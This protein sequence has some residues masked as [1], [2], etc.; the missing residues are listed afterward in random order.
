MFFTDSGFQSPVEVADVD[1][2]SGRIMHRGERSRLL[3][4]IIVFLYVRGSVLNGIRRVR[5]EVF[6]QF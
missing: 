6:F 1:F 4:E 2:G 3:E 5:V